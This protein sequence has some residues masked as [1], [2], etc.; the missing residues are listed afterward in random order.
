MK[1]EGPKN[2]I[3]AAVFG[4]SAAVAVPLGAMLIGMALDFE[5]RA[6]YK[7]AS[8]VMIICPF[9]FAKKAWDQANEDLE[10]FTK[11]S[12]IG[13]PEQLPEIDLDATLKMAKTQKLR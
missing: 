7:S 3:I 5:H 12:K 13:T 1:K 6:F 9:V 10:K 8:T 2:P 11:R 4:F